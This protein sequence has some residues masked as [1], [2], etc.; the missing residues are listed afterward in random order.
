[1]PAI[2]SAVKQDL[3]DMPDKPCNCGRWDP[4]P[5]SFFLMSDVSLSLSLSPPLS[6][7]LPPSLPPPHRV[8]VSQL[9]V[10]AFLLSLYPTITD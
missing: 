9:P 10:V 7:S 6:L 3:S 5:V 4:L 1:M 2:L 8:T